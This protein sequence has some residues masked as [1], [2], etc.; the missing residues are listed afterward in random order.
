LS[1]SGR[2]QARRLL[3]EAP[4]AMNQEDDSFYDAVII[5]GGPAGLSAALV[6]GRCRRKVLVIDS[7]EPR[8][9]AAH[10]VHGYLG[11]EGV[12]PLG[13]RELGQ[14]EIARYG[15]QW[16][17]D[18]ATEAERLAVDETYPTL[19]SVKTA[20][21]RM[22]T[23]RKLLFATGMRDELPDFPGI[24]EC[25]GVSV[26]HCPYCDGWEHTGQ[27][28]LVYGEPPD[29]AVGLAINVRTWSDEVTVV[30][31][32]GPLDERD[33]QRLMRSG[34]AFRPEMIVRLV[35]DGQQ[36]RGVEL[37]GYGTLAAD[38][39]F[40][41]TNQ[42]PQCDLPA[43]LGVECVEGDEI[44]SPTNRKQRTNVPG[45]LLAGD[46]DGN[47]QFAIVAAAE[48]A[49]AAAAIHKELLEEDEGNR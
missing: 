1:F 21:G 5:G 7:G 32:G 42:Q 26:H 25:Y 33:R 17:A 27:R 38:S 6:L 9:A 15:A 3:F 23:S 47:V 2:S 30:T 34:I 45:V 11:H 19:F 46:A 37:A 31:N 8:N 39:L 28:I 14:A 4:Q 41:N 36:L 44:T 16:L 20:N 13:L 40:F 35:H 24:R 18:R 22:F 49:T 29:S 48:G 43:R 12:A 10:A